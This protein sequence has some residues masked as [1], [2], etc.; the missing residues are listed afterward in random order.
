VALCV[1]F[2]DDSRVNNGESH[3]DAPGPAGP[4]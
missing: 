4:A 2:C 1:Q 3:R